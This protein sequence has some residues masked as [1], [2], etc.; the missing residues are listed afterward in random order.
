[1]DGQLIPGIHRKRSRNQGTVSTIT[2]VQL[3]AT[4]CAPRRGKSSVRRQA[5]TASCTATT[6]TPRVAHSGKA[7]P[8]RTLPT[9]PSARQPA[10]DRAQLPGVFPDLTG[11]K[12]IPPV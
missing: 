1:M 2:T 5:I 10:I 12:S 9:T 4:T 6:P 7:S 11:G 8:S 3:S